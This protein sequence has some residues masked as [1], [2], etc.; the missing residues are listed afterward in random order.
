MGRH[1]DCMSFA[2][3]FGDVRSGFMLIQGLWSKQGR[4]SNCDRCCPSTCV[5]LR[6]RSASARDS[7]AAAAP[8]LA[9]VP[10][11][12]LRL[13]IRKPGCRVSCHTC[14]LRAHTGHCRLHMLQEADPALQMLIKIH[15]KHRVLN[16]MQRSNCMAVASYQAAAGLQ[17]V[18]PDQ[19]PS[20]QR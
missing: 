3:C 4:R 5:A 13:S 12:E 11:K 8:A 6:S 17:V 10:T 14:L 18:H 9:C 7:S 20:L 16:N 1:K 19:G 2:I 15:I